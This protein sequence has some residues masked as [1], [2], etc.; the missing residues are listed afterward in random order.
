M[1]KFHQTLV[2]DFPYIFLQFF[3]GNFSGHWEEKVLQTN[4][5]KIL[6]SAFSA[7]T[8]MLRPQMFAVELSGVKP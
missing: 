8:C 6:R 5:K 1:L 4:V 3:P 7:C 2:L